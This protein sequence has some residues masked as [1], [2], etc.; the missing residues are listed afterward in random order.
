VSN[1]GA[2]V[3]RLDTAT[4]SIRLWP[5]PASELFIWQLALGSQETVIGNFTGFGPRG[6][7]RLDMAT[8]TFTIW[9]TG[10]AEP[11]Y[12]IASDAAGGVYFRQIDGSAWAVSR[13]DP[14]TGQ[15]TQWQAASG[16]GDRMIFS[17]GMALFGINGSLTALDV[18]RP[19]ANTTLSP[20]API[21][22]APVSF[23]V[24]PGVQTVVGEIATAPVDSQPIVRA[25]R[26]AYD[27]WAAGTANDFAITSASPDVYFTDGTAD[28]RVIGRVTRN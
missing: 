18:S 4:G 3:G 14:A 26:A 8:N 20:S 7:F 16:I 25:H 1:V 15:L 28:H 19:G 12:A 27:T 21:V 11:I 9:S 6:L 24:S 2:Y 17:D 22:V 13:F 23:T 5:I 10:S